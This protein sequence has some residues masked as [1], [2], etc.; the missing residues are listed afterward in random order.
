VS[1]Y[2]SWRG[3]DS[4]HEEDCAFW[5]EVEDGLFEMGDPENCTCGLPRA[6]LIYQGSH[7]L[8]SDEDPKGGSVEIA[9]IGDHITRDGRDDAKEGEPKDWLRLGVSN[10]ASQETNEDGSPYIKAGD[11]TVVLTRPHVEILRDELTAW[12]ERKPES[13]ALEGNDA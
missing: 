8:P 9:S 5:V 7:V 4:E 6:P 2:A 10:E 1:I 13:E 3:L 12:L 11:A